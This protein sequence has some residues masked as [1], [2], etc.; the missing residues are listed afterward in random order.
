M[1]SLIYEQT[2]SRLLNSSN[3]QWLRFVTSDPASNIFHHPA[4]LDLLAECYG[5]RPFIIVLCDP[6]GLIRTGLPI[7]EVNSF[8]T[9]RRWVSLPFSDHCMP[10]KGDNDNLHQL[11]DELVWNFKA[12]M[13][14]KIELRTEL[15]PHPAFRTYSNYVLHTLELGTDVD[16]LLSQV[17]SMH[18][19]NIKVAKKKGV[20]VEWGN[21]REHIEKYYHLHLCTR[22]RQGMPVQPKRFF[23]L[24]NTLIFNKGL[25]YVLLAYKQDECIAGA[26]FLHWQRTLTYKY[27]ASNILGRDLRANNLLMWTG[28]QWGCENGFIELDMGRSSATNSG[29]RTYKNRWGAREVPLVYSVLP[30]ELPDSKGDRLTAVMQTIIRHSPAWV[31]K[32]TG[33][34]L[35]RHVA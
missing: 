25:G 17:H 34:L 5:Y 21:G 15:L 8:L 24:L 1:N 10:V 22:R 32:I 33:K 31:C 7:M 18:R 27:G 11:A 35:Y 2:E 6:D 19:R 3:E 26:V 9:G 23:D 20:F 28:I 12:C 13:Q 14:P 30:N 4:W 16:S 29:L